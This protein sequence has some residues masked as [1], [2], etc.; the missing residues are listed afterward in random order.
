MHFERE[1]RT[2]GEF[3]PVHA[4]GVEAGAYQLYLVNSV[5]DCLDVKRSAK[6]KRATGQMTHLTFLPSRIDQ[7]LPAFRIPQ[8]PTFV[9][10]NAAFVEAL[11]RFG[12]NGL[13]PLVV[14]SEDH[15]IQ[16]ARAPM[17]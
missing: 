5:I 3:I 8:S 16:P 1:L 15:S 10:W 12:A 7:S 6:P 11:Q 13:V 4:E 14:W 17:R 2:A 9:F